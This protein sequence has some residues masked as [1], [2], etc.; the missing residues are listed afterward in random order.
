MVR[1]A[2]VLRLLVETRLWFGFPYESHEGGP[3]KEMPSQP[4][5][6]A[7]S[8][9]FRKRKSFPAYGDQCHANH[10]SASI[11]VSMAVARYS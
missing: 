2:E 1:D 9:H 10:P 8:C 7:F 4:R 5:G 11:D 3:E 6:R